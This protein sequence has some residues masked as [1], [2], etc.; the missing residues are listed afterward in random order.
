MYLSKFLEKYLSCLKLAQV[1]KE[2]FETSNLFEKSSLK[3]F[4]ALF[5]LAHSG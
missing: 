1:N 5:E 4:K 3:I 2:K